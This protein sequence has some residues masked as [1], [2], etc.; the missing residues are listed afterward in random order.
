VYP[1]PVSNAQPNYI[2]IFSHYIYDNTSLYVHAN[3]SNN[4]FLNV[5]NEVNYESVVE[6]KLSASNNINVMNVSHSNGESESNK[7]KGNPISSVNLT[8]SNI[9]HQNDWPVEVIATLSDCVYS[10]ILMIVVE[11]P[12]RYDVS[13]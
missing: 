6:K 1:S 13:Y 12:R 5:K 11:G 10:D 4:N 9:S 3:S 8:A 2:S 7:Q